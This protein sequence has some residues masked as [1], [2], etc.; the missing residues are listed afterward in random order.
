[1]ID[2]DLRE[3]SSIYIR[4]FEDPELKEEWTEESAYALLCDWYKRQPDLA[5]SAQWENKLVGAFIIGV[6]PWWDGNHLVDGELFVAPEAQM[7]REL[8]RQVL[9]T[10]KQ[11]YAP[12]TWET[13]TF[14]GQ[15][16]PLGWIK[17]GRL[18][19]WRTT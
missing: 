5:F 7:G 11:K 16:F 4:A 3:L 9:L 13:Y 17:K 1:M 19:S 12:V 18:H 8:V 10:A 6:R 2:Q 14:R 15:E